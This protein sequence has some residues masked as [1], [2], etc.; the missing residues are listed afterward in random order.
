MSEYMTLN[1]RCCPQY[2]VKLMWRNRGDDIVSVAAICA[3]AQLIFLFVRARLDM[4]LACVLVRWAVSC[5]TC[6]C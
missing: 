5:I 2:D 6:N 3:A 4:L 1:S